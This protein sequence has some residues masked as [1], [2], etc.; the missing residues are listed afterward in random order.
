MKQLINKIVLIILLLSIG[1]IDGYAQ[2]KK[3]DPPPQSQKKGNFQKKTFS[4]SN[5]DRPIGPPDPGG[6]GG[7]F[8]IPI[9]GGMVFLFISGTLYF[10]RKAKNED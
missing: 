9:S 5:P 2:F 7:G 4:T 6:G 10:I 3:Q 1:G 8:P